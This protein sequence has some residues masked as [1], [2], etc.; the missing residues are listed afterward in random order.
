MATSGTTTLQL[1][2]DQLIEAALRKLGVLAK[3]Q[4]PDTE[5][6]TNG[7]QALNALFAEL[8]GVGMPMW[9]RKTYSFSP[10][11]AVSTYNI[12]VS[13]TLNTPYPLDLMQA[14]RTESTTNV[15]MM[16]MTDYDFNRLST[17]SSGMPVHVTYQAKVNLGVLK[18]WPTPDSGAAAST[19]TLVYHRPLEYFTAS[20]DTMDVP[21]DWYL[22]VIYK[23]AVLLAPEWGVPLE[24]R[25]SLGKEADKF[26]D[27]AKNNTQDVVSIYFQ[28][29]RD[30]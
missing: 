28:P 10:T 15:D 25:Q 9:T 23:L 22:A 5:D 18:L 19:I 26:V 30:F 17:S 7:A 21:E 12:G 2:R 3:G 13:Q 27:T 14:Y 11:A 6:Y 4:T 29:N 24:D 16:I 8:R 20:A 1:T